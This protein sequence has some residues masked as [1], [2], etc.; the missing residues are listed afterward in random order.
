[1]IIDSLKTI[2]HNKY[3]HFIYK[4]IDCKI[5]RRQ[6]GNKIINKIKQWLK[7]NNYFIILQK[8][9]VTSKKNSEETK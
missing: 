6:F 2:N 5:Y 3:K 1:M 4:I 7:W 9:T 8:F